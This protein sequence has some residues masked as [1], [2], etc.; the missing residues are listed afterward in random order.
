VL[1]RTRNVLNG[2]GRAIRIIYDYTL[3]QSTAS[4]RQA[5]DYCG[6]SLVGRFMNMPAKIAGYPSQKSEKDKS[7]S[8]PPIRDGY[9]N[10]MKLVLTIERTVI[11]R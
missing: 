8:F 6:R 3:G 5:Y 9:L 7:Y 11:H 10:N 1:T 4:F 2:L